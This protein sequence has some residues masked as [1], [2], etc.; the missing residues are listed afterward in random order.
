MVILLYLIVFYESFVSGPVT[1]LLWIVLFTVESIFL[2]GGSWITY[3]QWKTMS[4]KERLQ[5]LFWV[6]L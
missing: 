4:K 2:V 6:V 1:R 3:H 5:A